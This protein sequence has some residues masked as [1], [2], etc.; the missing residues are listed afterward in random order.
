MGDVLLVR[1]RHTC[2]EV[3]FTI[4]SYWRTKVVGLEL[5]LMIVKKRDT[6]ALNYEHFN[7]KINRKTV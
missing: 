5:R 1:F 7:K 2:Q 6:R 4:T 3:S